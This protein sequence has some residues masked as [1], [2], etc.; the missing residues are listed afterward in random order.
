MQKAYWRKHYWTFITLISHKENDME[1][2]A[3]PPNFKGLTKEATGLF[4]PAESAGNGVRRRAGESK[5]ERRWERVRGT[6][7]YCS[8]EEAGR[9]GGRGRRKRECG[10]ERGGSVACL[11]KRVQGGAARRRRLLMTTAASKAPCPSFPYPTPLQPTLTPL[12]QQDGRRRDTPT[13]PAPL[14]PSPSPGGSGEDFTCAVTTRLGLRRWASWLEAERRRERGVWRGRRLLIHF[15]YALLAR[16][17]KFANVLKSLFNDGWN[18]LTWKKDILFHLNMYCKFI[19]ASARKT[20]VSFKVKSYNYVL[21][22]F[23]Q[24]VRIDM[25]GIG[26][27]PYF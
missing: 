21:R 3:F 15:S 11:G 13:F 20:K 7:L 5:R 14:F 17:I 22:I 1:M 27:I 2:K 26:E 4:T 25:P 19:S 23:Q 16:E 9:E 18:A 12:P 24:I 6:W 8:S 10:E